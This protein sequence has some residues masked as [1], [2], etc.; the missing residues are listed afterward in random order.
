MNERAL[1]I[2]DVQNDLCGGRYPLRSRASQG[3]A[4]AI[5]RF[6]SRN[7]AGIVRT[8]R[9]IRGVSRVA[10]DYLLIRYASNLES[11]LT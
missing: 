2:V 1:I 5:I 6:I 10:L 11:V 4:S 7:R 3:V 9:T 8:W